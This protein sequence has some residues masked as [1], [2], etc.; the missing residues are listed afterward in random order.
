MEKW[1]DSVVIS[2]L[3]NRP[4]LGGDIG[5][6]TDTINGI[7]K[8]GTNFYCYE[9]FNLKTTDT[10]KIILFNFGA[11]ES[12][13]KNYII[14]VDS[15][16]SRDLFFFLGENELGDDLT[17]IASYFKKNGRILKEKYQIEILDLFL[18]CKLGEEE[19][20]KYIY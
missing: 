9:S 7:V 17:K 12:E 11:Y 13:G 3:N 4:I 1:S 8:R 16:P 15:L 20:P 14:V 18:R 19:T 6:K 2:F 10:T 5:F